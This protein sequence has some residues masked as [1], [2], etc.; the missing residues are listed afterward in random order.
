MDPRLQWP[1]AFIQRRING[2]WENGIQPLKI[3]ILDYAVY[4]RIH[5][6]YIANYSISGIVSHLSDER[7][8]GRR[9][10]G[11]PFTL[12]FPHLFDSFLFIV[13]SC[14]S[15]DECSEEALVL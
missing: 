4:I 3:Q 10:Y 8:G 11:L 2:I 6:L 1:A 7:F 13:N 9:Q 14:L 5:I 15:S 12:S